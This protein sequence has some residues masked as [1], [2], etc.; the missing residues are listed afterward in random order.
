M[1]FDIESLLD[2]VGWRIL[3]ELQSDARLSMAELGRRVGLSAPATAER[4]RKLE[5]AGVISG[6]RAQIDLKRVGRPVMAFVRITA[7]GDVRTRVAEAARHSPEVLEVHRGTGSD[8]FI[9]KIAV[10]DIAHL[11][12]VTDR[13]TKFGQ[14]TT[15]IVLSSLVDRRNIEKLP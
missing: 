4:V 2:G 8:C 1:A 9:L 12:G 5:D 14:L 11:E 15:S 7:L 3:A 13:F 10:E 6:Y